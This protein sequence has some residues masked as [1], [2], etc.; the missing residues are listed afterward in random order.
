MEEFSRSAGW[1]SI[2]LGSIAGLRAGCVRSSHKSIGSGADTGGVP[3]PRK[4][5]VTR[6]IRGMDAVLRPHGWDR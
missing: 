1:L 4:S 3:R 6:F 2:R 5:P